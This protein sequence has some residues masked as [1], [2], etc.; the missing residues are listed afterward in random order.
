MNRI[1]RRPAKTRQ[2]NRH[3]VALLQFDA[4][5]EAERVRPKEMDVRVAGTP[6][7]SVFESRGLGGRRA[8]GGLNPGRPCY[9]TTWNSIHELAVRGVLPPRSVAMA[10]R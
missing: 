4:V 9:S 8:H 3:H 6:V 1:A 10:C 5:S 2:F 7:G